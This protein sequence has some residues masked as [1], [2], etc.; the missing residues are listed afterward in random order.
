[1]TITDT[2]FTYLA[3]NVKLVVISQYANEKHFENNYGDIIQ[4]YLEDTSI[5]GA[6]IDLTE[7]SI[8]WD[9]L[10][11]EIVSTMKYGCEGK[12]HEE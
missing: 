6:N 12:Y 3:Q 10:K 9:N 7:K 2:R 11:D 5:N 8:F 1:M 4:V